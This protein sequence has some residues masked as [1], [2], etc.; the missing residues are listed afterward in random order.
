MRVSTG[1]SAAQRLEAIYSLSQLEVF[2]AD[3]LVAMWRA[4]LAPPD[5]APGAPVKLEQLAEHDAAVRA[6][7]AAADAFAV[8][9]MRIRLDHALAHDNSIGKPFRTTLAHTVA[10]Y[11]HDLGLLH[12]RVAATAV[13]VDPHGAAATAER[14]VAEAR[15]VLG[16]RAALHDGLF[17]LA[18]D[19]AAAM[20]PHVTTAARDRYQADDVR[21]RWLVVR[22]DLELT[23]EDPARVARAPLAD[24]L[25]SIP[26]VDEVP[27]EAPE[28]TLGEL[29]EPY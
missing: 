25:K 21:L 14:V 7:L 4:E 20:I 2:D 26:A 1:Q 28:L 13:R 11:A 29:I 19:H 22:R 17:T 23:V 18:R 5:A 24:R 8:R 27:E 9:A 3:E 16:A 15:A 10:A 6:A 12:D